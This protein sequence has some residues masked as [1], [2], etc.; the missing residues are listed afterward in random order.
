MNYWKDYLKEVKNL[1]VVEKEQGFYVYQIW[2]D[3]IFVE[4]FYI[5]PELRNKKVGQSFVNE[6]FQ[7]AK[8]HNKKMLKCLV[9]LETNN[10]AQNLMIYLHCGGIIWDAKYPHISMCLLVED[11]K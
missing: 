6:L 8:Q 10:Y 5:V 1:T 9:D 2:E 7:I 4:H 3:S 11:L